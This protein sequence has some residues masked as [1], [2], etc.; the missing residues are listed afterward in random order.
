MFSTVFL[1]VKKT[2]ISFFRVHS[3]NVELSFW[4]YQD[5]NRVIFGGN[6]EI[7]NERLL[8]QKG[9]YFKLKWPK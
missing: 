5:K 4:A 7:L 3:K 9:L 1:S 6:D 8:F 2:R